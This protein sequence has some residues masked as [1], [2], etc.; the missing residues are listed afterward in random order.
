M[1]DLKTEYTD[2]KNIRHKV[3]HVISENAKNS[4]ERIIKELCDVL[5]KKNP[6]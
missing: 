2:V 4:R 1:A 3:E 5:A 6:T